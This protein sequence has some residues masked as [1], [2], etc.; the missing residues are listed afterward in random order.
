MIGLEAR[1][2]IKG[3]IA[4]QIPLIKLEKTGEKIWGDR[5]DW[6]SEKKA[7][8]TGIRLFRDIYSKSR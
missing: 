3:K 6:I 5:C 2:I 4:R 8:E 7:I 1:E